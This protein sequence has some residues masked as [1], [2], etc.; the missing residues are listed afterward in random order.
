[1]AA[2]AT[3]SSPFPK[4]IPIITRSPHADRLALL[5]EESRAHREEDDDDGS[6]RRSRRNRRGSEK[7]RG[8]DRVTGEVEDEAE[9]YEV[10]GQEARDHAREDRGPA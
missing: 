7:R 5:E 2:T 1:M 6:R 8:D 10:A 9:A 3:A 4:S